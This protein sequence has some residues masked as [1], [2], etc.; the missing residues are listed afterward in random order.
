MT[1]IERTVGVSPGSRLA[2]AFFASW[3]RN[4]VPLAWLCLIWKPVVSPVCHVLSDSWL[5]LF[6]TFNRRTALKQRTIKVLKRC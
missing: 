4:F 1:Y 2:I 5:L 6:L 3:G